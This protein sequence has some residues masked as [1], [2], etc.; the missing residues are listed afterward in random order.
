MP[1]TIPNGADLSTPYAMVSRI[2]AKAAHHD[3]ASTFTQRCP[4]VRAHA[5][6]S[7]LKTI[8]QHLSPVMTDFW[9]RVTI[10]VQTRAAIRLQMPEN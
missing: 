1:L 10:D 6:Q 8:D 5:K 4:L 2:T 3:L 7:Q 9:V